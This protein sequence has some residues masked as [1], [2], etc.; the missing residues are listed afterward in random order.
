MLNNPNTITA[1]VAMAF[2]L[3]VLKAFWYRMTLRPKTDI[4]Y[5]LTGIVLMTIAIFWRLF[6]WD[7]SQHLMMLILSENIWHSTVGNSIGAWSN[8]IVNIIFICSFYCWLEAI[9]KRLP[10]EEQDN[11]NA[12]TIAFYPFKL[13]RKR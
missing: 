7:A 5:F 11:W 4:D 12:F 8:A 1:F 13:F 9:V 2:S 6:Y 10:L 3:L